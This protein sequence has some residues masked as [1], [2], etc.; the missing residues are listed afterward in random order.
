MTK[1]T[2]PKVAIRKANDKDAEEIANLYFNTIRTEEKNSK[3]LKWK[4]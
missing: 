3:I 2:E 4:R 1:K